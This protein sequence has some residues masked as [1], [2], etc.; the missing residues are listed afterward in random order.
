MFH[1]LR[2]NDDTV[3]VKIQNAFSLAERLRKDGPT[4]LSTGEIESYLG[5]GGTAKILRFLLVKVKNQS[6]SCDK[7]VPSVYALNVVAYELLKDN[8][9]V[10]G[11]TNKEAGRKIKEESSR[12]MLAFSSTQRDGIQH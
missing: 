1:L 4:P 5:V 6:G 2:F 10:L 11:M 8:F 9:R 12:V 7:S 3:R